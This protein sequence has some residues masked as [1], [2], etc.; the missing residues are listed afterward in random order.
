VYTPPKFV[1]I[2]YELR[3]DTNESERRIELLQHNLRRYGT[4]YTLSPPPATCTDGSS[5]GSV[6]GDTVKAWG[7]T[8][9]HPQQPRESA[10]T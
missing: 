1:E 10:A 4:V 7:T 5:P 9:A 8:R 2:T 3:L 6:I